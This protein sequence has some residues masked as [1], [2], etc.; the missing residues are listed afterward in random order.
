MGHC[1]RVTLKNVRLTSS[2]LKQLAEPALFAYT[3]VWLQEEKT[4]R[5]SKARRIA[6]HPVLRKYVKHLTCDFLGADLSFM[7]VPEG[8]E[9]EGGGQEGGAQEEGEEEEEKFLNPGGGLYQKEYPGEAFIQLMK[10]HLGYQWDWHRKFHCNR[11]TWRM[12]YSML[13]RFSAVSSVTVLRPKRHLM[14]DESRQFGMIVS[15]P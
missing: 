11:N 5:R 14:P 7:S 8:R 10:D 1:D 9:G 6:K 12:L 3:Y 15:V 13:K 4:V 2:L